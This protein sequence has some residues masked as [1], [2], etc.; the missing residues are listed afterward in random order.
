MFRFL[1]TLFSVIYDNTVGGVVRMVQHAATGKVDGHDKVF[2]RRVL[3]FT[4]F[5]LLAIFAPTWAI[6]L[7]L[8]R[9]MSLTEVFVTLADIFQQTANSYA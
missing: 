2:F 1:N 8:L 7:G 4:G 6:L 3:L 9:F 5:T